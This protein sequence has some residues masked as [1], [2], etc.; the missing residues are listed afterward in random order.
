MILTVSPLFLEAFV[1]PSNLQFTGQTSDSLRFRW[2]PAG[3]PVSA[4]VIQHV[5]LTGLGQPV[6]AEMRQVSSGW[7]ASF[8][9]SF[10]I[11]YTFTHHLM[12]H[13]KLST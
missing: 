12:I 9:I 11:G 5:P 13:K 6:I 7:S 4:Y 10:S 3:G 2:S 8:I 1:G